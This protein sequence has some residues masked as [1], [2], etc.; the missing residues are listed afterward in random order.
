[1]TTIVSLR[2]DDLGSVQ[3][4]QQLAYTPEL[5]EPVEV[6][7]TRL[8]LAPDFCFGAREDAESRA[9]LAY[10]IAHPWPADQSP[11]L[12]RELAA[13]PAGCDAVHLHDMAVNPA[14]GGRGLGRALLEHLVAVSEAAGFAQITLV[15]VQDAAGFWKK[16]G[17]K[18]QR[19][20]E[21]YD[22]VATLM[23]LELR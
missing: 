13:L 7:S 8:S 15:A 19:A 23:R 1:M 6:F 3:R 16:M 9:L 22:E 20:V 2:A 11:G 17:F 10:L 14:A 18:A 5:L 4:I 21:G 12:S